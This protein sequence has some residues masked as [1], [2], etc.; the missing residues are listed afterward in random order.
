VCGSHCN[1]TLVTVNHEHEEEAEEE[2][3]EVMGDN[4]YQWECISSG[5]TA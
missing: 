4:Q 5:R 1:L 3:E 2:E